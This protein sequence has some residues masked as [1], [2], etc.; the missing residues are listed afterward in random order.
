[1]E[2]HL[3]TYEL[4]QMA[5]GK[6]DTLSDHAYAK[7][8][9]NTCPFCQEQIAYMKDPV[10]AA[11]SALTITTQ[12][13]LAIG[14]VYSPAFVEGVH[15]IP[16]YIYPVVIAGGE[17]FDATTGLSTIAIMNMHDKLSL[18]AEGDLYTTE[19]SG[20]FAGW[21]VC[22]WSKREVLSQILRE[23]NF[24]GCL[25]DATT[26]LLST[27]RSGQPP[28]DSEAFCHAPTAGNADAA[29][30]LRR[31]IYRDYGTLSGD[32]IAKRG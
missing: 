19:S 10:A 25:N 14:E 32:L 22:L 2:R 28:T 11:C 31:R 1:M 29:T 20:P 21:V 17:Q 30:Q 9:L 23:G 18:A 27:Y 16:E 26:T 24:L 8:H 5:V 13:S 6:A 15:R 12:P 4:T 7:Y 3:S